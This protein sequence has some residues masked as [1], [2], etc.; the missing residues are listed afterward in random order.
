MFRNVYEDTCAKRTKVGNVNL[1]ACE[2]LF[3]GEMVNFFCRSAIN[4][5]ACCLDGFRPQV[6]WNCTLEAQTPSS[7]H[8]GP[9]HSFG[10]SITLGCERLTSFVFNSC[11]FAELTKAVGNVFAAVV[12]AKDFNFFSCIVLDHGLKLAEFVIDGILGF[13]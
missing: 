3:R 6:G 4:E 8:K 13:D 11:E 1:L 10:Y 7:F 12:R 5:V 2:H 9:V